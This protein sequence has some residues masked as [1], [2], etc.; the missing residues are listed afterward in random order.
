[1]STMPCSATAAER[2]YD[3]G[4]EMSDRE[5]IDRADEIIDAAA[6][7]QRVNSVDAVDLLRET[8]SERFSADVSD[9]IRTA[10]FYQSYKL[11]ENDESIK[12]LG[13]KVFALVNSAAL[14]TA[15]DV[16]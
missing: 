12:A 15:H 16:F 13:R 14:D 10:A 3:G 7:N 6:S 5:I 11:A 1:M 9:L 2:L 8:I 4:G